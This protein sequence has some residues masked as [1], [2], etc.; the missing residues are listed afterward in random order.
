MKV[1]KL[2]EF[3]KS[4]SLKTLNSPVLLWE[5]PAP[6]ALKQLNTP[7]EQ[8]KESRRATTVRGLPQPYDDDEPQP[9]AL[10]LQVMKTDGAPN[11]FGMGVTVGRL[12]TNDVVLDEP[13]VSR[14][15]A[16]FVQSREGIWALVDAESDF[17]TRVDLKRL[18]PKTPT[19]LTDGARLQ[20]GKVDLLFLSVRSLMDRV[21]RTK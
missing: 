20:F 3:A 11:P 4:I 12:E 21:G 7:S 13:S 10:V 9:P 8:L 5:K 19:P 18:T 14:F 6:T 17:G 1:F 16:W 2:S 15:H